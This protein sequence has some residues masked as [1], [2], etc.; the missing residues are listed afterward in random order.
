VVAVN[1][2][3]GEKWMIMIGMREEEREKERQVARM[4]EKI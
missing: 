3:K 2:I 4:G 1:V